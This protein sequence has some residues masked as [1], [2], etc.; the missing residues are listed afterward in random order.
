MVI[1]KEFYP[2]KCNRLG[3]ILD[4][5]YKNAGF[6]LFVSGMIEGSSSFMDLYPQPFVEDWQLP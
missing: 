6:T 4:K 5:V 3:L 1:N 2:M